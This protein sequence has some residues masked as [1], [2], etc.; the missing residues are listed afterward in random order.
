LRA[1][2]KCCWRVVKAGL[3][4][5]T[6]LV[7]VEVEEVVEAVD[8]D[9]ARAWRREGAGG[10][11]EGGFSRATAGEVEVVL[12]DVWEGGRR[13]VEVVRV[14]AEDLVRAWPRGGGAAAA[15]EVVVGRRP[16]EL[17]GREIGGDGPE[18]EVGRAAGGLFLVVMGGRDAVVVVAVVD[19]DALWA[20]GCRTE[21]DLPRPKT[22]EMGLLLTVVVVSAPLSSFLLAAIDAALV[23]RDVEVEVVPLTGNLLGDTLRALFWAS[24]LESA[25]FFCPN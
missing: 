19:D 13:I 2:E 9:L 14:V 6:G 10:G 12:V 15:V 21:A 4:R 22:P 16:D 20:G 5:R 7:E 8:T 24:W 1:G 18:E 23:V 11:R 3:R 25:S 17:V